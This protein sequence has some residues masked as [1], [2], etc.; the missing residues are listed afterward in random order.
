MP[1]TTACSFVFRARNL[2]LIPVVLALVV[3]GIATGLRAADSAAGR[4]P[5]FLTLTNISSFQRTTNAAGERE[6]LSD[7]LKGGSAWDELVLS[8]NA[9]APLGSGL[10][11]EVRVMNGDRATKFYNLGL[12]TEDTAE[13]RRESV[14]DQKDDDATVLTDTLRLSRPATR[15]QLRVTLLPAASGEVPTV[16]RLGVSLI[17]RGMKFESQPPFK[18]AWGKVLAVPERSQLSYEGGRDWCSPTSVSMVLAYWAGQLKRPALDIDVP[19]VAA[20]VFDPS[21]P[22]TGNWPFNTA[23]AGRQPGMRAAVVRFAD[24]AEL[25]TLI[26]AG[27]PVV[28]SISYQLLYDRPSSA[29]NGHLVVCI[30]LTE[31]GDVVINDPW[32]DF[33]KGDKVR[34]VI[35]RANFVKAWAHSKNTAYLIHPESW[36]MPANGAGRW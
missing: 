20:G 26:A 32:A 8:W 35:P 6:C 5:A 21:W 12:W 9:T 1:V 19:D 34:A 13:R 22:G 4:L 33:K 14:N 27:V 36:P 18:P 17:D 23:F 24:V 3:S 31:K 16:R 29:S 28:T 11:F 30:G 25:E 10:K 15:F 2:K 7:W